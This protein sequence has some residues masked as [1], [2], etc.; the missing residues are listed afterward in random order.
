MRKKRLELRL[1][2][3]LLAND[4]AADRGPELVLTDVGLDAREEV[5]CIHNTGLVK[6]ERLAVNEIGSGPGEHVQ[7]AARVAPVLRRVIVQLHRDRL[8]S[9][10]IGVV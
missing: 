5:G 1:I 10:M 9:G 2:K 4:R 7:D 3:E 8:Q 6:Q